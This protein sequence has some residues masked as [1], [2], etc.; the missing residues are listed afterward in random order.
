MIIVK[1]GGQ[2]GIN[3]DYVLEDFAKQKDILLVHGGKGVLEDISTQLGKPPKWVKTASGF[4]SRRTD[5][6]TMDMFTMVYAGKQN[7]MIVEKL[8][9]LGVN[10]VG[11]CGM[12]G[13]T[14]IAKRKIIKIVEEGKKRVLRDD[15]TGKI[16]QVNPELLRNLIQAGFAPV[17]CPPALSEENEPLNVDGDRMA[18][19]IAKAFKAD[20]VI[21]LSN[22]P[23]LLKDKDDESSLIEEINKDN[24][25]EFMQYAQGTMKKKVMGAME[26]VDSG[27]S[28]VIFA[29]ARLEN[30]ITNA[31]NG[32]GT[33]IH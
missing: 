26:A 9:A 10:A 14:I 33:V 3:Y 15:Y 17:I 19:E 5:R 2:K 20:T 25:E 4:T 8:Q 16:T 6:E 32:K 28:K 13:R 30:P 27:V 12:D 18:A 11:L 23:G 24:V 21:Y 22:V 31:L 29:D 1:V 7:K